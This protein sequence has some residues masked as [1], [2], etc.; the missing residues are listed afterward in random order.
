MMSTVGSK[1][2]AAGWVPVAG[3]RSPVG[4]NE[5]SVGVVDELAVVEG[6]PAIEFQPAAPATTRIASVAR[7]AGSLQQRQRALRTQ[8]DNDGSGA[9]GPS[10]GGEL[11]DTEQLRHLMQDYRNLFNQLV[12]P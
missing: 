2:E 4:P 6:L 7:A 1:E 8:W 9:A 11:S 10:D 12:Q 3:M 5:E